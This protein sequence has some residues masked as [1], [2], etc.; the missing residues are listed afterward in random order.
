MAYLLP[1]LMGHMPLQIEPLASA[2]S[3]QPNK[4]LGNVRQSHIL[5]TRKLGPLKLFDDAVN[6]TY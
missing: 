5:Y 4:L 6:D 2:L 1:M 3:Y